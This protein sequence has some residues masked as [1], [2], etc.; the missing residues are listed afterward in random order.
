MNVRLTVAAL[1]T[2][3]LLFG[4]VGVLRP[5]L[6]LGA[7]GFVVVDTSHTAFIVGEI[8]ATYGGVFTAM[9]VVVL[10]AVVD[11]YRYRDRILVVGLLWLGACVARLFGTSVDGSPGLLGWASAMFEGIVGVLLS[12]ASR[13]AR[14]EVVTPVGPGA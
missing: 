1:G 4:L 5:E 7:L 3:I 9:G 8:R 2:V 13:L 11:P 14:S 10:W 12:L 6:V